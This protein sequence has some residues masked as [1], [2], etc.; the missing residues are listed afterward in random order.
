MK[1]DDKL[2]IGDIVIDLGNYSST[3]GAVGSIDT[4]S[5]SDS[6]LHTITLPDPSSYS[7]N[8]NTSSGSYIT[9]GSSPNYTFS[10][11]STSYTP[12]VNI[13]SNGIDIKD[14]GDIKVDGKSLKE[15]MTK[16]EQRLSILVPDPEKLE[17]FEA[18]KKAYEHYKTMES[19]CFPEKEDT[20]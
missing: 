8:W 2:E 17:K 12:T 3:A 1:D 7:M 10:N 13:D 15:F 16:M 6:N 18:L 14:G 20:E 4:I 9:T 5:I 19:L 11:I